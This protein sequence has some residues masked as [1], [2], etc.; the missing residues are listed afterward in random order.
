MAIEA[1]LAGQQEYLSTYYSHDIA[2]NWLFEPE[3][4][5]WR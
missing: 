5:Q 2:L 4:H 3:K 1:V